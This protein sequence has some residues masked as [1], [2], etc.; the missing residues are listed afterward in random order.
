[1]LLAANEVAGKRK[2]TV[3]SKRAI[4]FFTSPQL[5]SYFHNWYTLAMDIKLRQIAYSEKIDLKNLLD[6][7]RQELYHVSLSYL[8]P[9]KYLDDY[10]TDTNRRPLFILADDKVAGFALINLRDPL[11]DGNKQAIAEFYVIPDY[12]NQDIGKIATKKIFDMY[13]GEWVIRV[14]KDNPAYDF[15]KKTIEEITGGNFEETIQNDEKW[16]GPVFYLKT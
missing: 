16:D 4:C 7:Y 11:S 9:Y 10:F 14:R 6:T 12:R 5:Y 2:Y 8:S 15:W 1:M 3:K 13:P